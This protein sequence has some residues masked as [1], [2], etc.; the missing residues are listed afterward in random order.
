VRLWR[1]F[2]EV[3]TD[4]DVFRTA[5]GSLDDRTEAVTSYISFCED[6]CVPTSTRVS[7]NNDRPGAQQSSDS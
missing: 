7:Y 3:W 4:W 5:T 2:G 1:I 6:S